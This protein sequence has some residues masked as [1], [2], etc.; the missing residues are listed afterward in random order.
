MLVIYRAPSQRESKFFAKLSR[1]SNKY[2]MKSDKF[3]VIGNFSAEKSSD[4]APNFMS[5]YELTNKV[6]APTCFKVQST[7][8]IVIP[9]CFKEKC[10]FKR[11]VNVKQ[12]CLKYAGR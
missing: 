11:S 6:K 10:G 1:V 4:D 9:K 3:I 12:S 7:P 2:T 5:L 8:A